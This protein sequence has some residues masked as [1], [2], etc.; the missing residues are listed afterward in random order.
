[1]TT[2]FCKL[3]PVLVGSR[4][5]E[6]NRDDS[7]WD[8][9]AHEGMD[10]HKTIIEYREKNDIKIDIMHRPLDIQL[11]FELNKNKDLKTRTL[12]DGVECIIPPK[13][14]LAMMYLTSLYRI[15]PY[16]DDNIINIQIWN[17]RVKTYLKLR[18][19]IDYKKFDD[20]IFNNE[21]SELYNQ[22]QDR[23]AIRF[24]EL[25]DTPIDLEQAEDGFFKDNVA[26][27]FD[28]DYLHAQ[29]AK[30]YRGTDEPLFKKFQSRG[31]VGLDEKKF[32]KGNQDEILQMIAEEIAVLMLERKIIPALD[33]EKEY[34]VDEWDDDLENISAHFA[35]NLCGQGFYFL[36]KYV[37]DHFE[38]VISVLGQINH[39]KIVKLAYELMNFD[40]TEMEKKSYIFTG[41]TVESYEIYKKLHGIYKEDIIYKNKWYKDDK[42]QLTITGPDTGKGIHNGKEFYLDIKQIGQV[43][44]FTQIYVNEDT[45]ARS[46][47]SVFS[48]NKETIEGKDFEVRGKSIKIKYRYASYYNSAHDCTCYGCDRCTDQDG[49]IDVDQYGSVTIVHPDKKPITK[50]YLNSYGSAKD[51]AICEKIARSLLQ[52]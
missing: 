24:S 27:K 48:K 44:T 37:I 35:T 38:L 36:R 6:R 30:L 2:D 14:V 51:F 7:D 29:V 15:I 40:S 18:S 33:L 8:I 19:E 39:G 28:H 11:L 26:R 25:G 22:F 52:C 9:I 43:I 4:A 47:D 3:K 46:D 20:D 5:A 50:Y 31:K 12:F 41:I 13:E 21:N 34:N 23:M 49:S 17:K 45:V 32:N 42:N 10:I 16:C 1:M